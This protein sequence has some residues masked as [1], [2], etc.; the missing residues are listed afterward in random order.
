MPPWVEMLFRAARQARNFSDISAPENCEQSSSGADQ[1][2]FVPLLLI[3]FPVVAEDV[4]G[5]F[6]LPTAAGAQ[7]LPFQTSPWPDAGAVEDT[8]LPCRPMT[9][10]SAAVP[11][12]S[13]ASATVP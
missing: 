13:C 6:P 4:G 5:T 12:R 9:L 8:G 7:A 1:A 2:G 3:L 10:G 11:P